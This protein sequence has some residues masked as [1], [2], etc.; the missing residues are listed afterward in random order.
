MLVD[1]LLV[2]SDRQTFS[3]SALCE[4]TVNTWVGT[5]PPY[6]HPFY[7]V[8]IAHGNATHDIQLS[9]ITSDNETPGSDYVTMFT[10]GLIKKE[11]IKAGCN[12]VLTLPQVPMG[13][14]KQFIGARIS[15]DGTVDGNKKLSDLTKDFYAG[16]NTTGATTIPDSLPADFEAQDKNDTYSVIITDAY[17]M[18]N[19]YE[20]LN[21]SVAWDPVTSPDWG[22]DKSTVTVTDLMK[23]DFSNASGTLPIDKGGTG[24]STADNALTALNG[25]KTSTAES[26]YRKKTDAIDLASDSDVT[27]ILAIKHGGTGKATE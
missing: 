27:G 25:V 12:Y 22:C 1:Q 7:L 13:Y 3:A 15:F 10:S 23:T 16:G 11:K 14:Y 20:F 24:Q 8:L 9:I 2:L 6:N 18:I 21:Q 19:P 17:H 26:T 4:K 5:N